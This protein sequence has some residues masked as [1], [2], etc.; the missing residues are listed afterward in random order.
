LAVIDGFYMI[1]NITTNLHLLDI[2]ME[3][4]LIILQVY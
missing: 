1:G 3:I 4:I 2:E